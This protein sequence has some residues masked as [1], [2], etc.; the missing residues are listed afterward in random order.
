MKRSFKPLAAFI[1]ICVMG[2]LLWLCFFGSN[3]RS[4]ESSLNDQCHCCKCQTGAQE[5]VQKRDS[6]TQI[7]PM[8]RTYIKI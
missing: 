3:R 1:L 6:L 2:Y 5:T 7:K 4:E 8:L